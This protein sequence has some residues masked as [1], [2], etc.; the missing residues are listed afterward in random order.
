M[1]KIVFDSVKLPSSFD[2][3]AKKCKEED[4]AEVGIKVS[5]WLRQPAH[6]IAINGYFEKCST[7]KPMLYRS[8]TKYRMERVLTKVKAKGQLN[9][10]KI[11]KSLEA[12]I[13]SNMLS[14]PTISVK[15]AMFYI[16]NKHYNFKYH[17]PAKAI[18]LKT[19]NGKPIGR[20]SQVQ[21]EALI[22]P[23]GDLHFCAPSHCSKVYK[24]V[25]E[26]K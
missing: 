15:G 10:Q 14:E 11:K 2:E 7:T 19:I 25:W 3:F 17:S 23:K 13:E 20:L 22:C 5:V 16:H 4:L 9:L 18:V 26:C 21:I 6:R 8:E 12:I 24:E 1:K